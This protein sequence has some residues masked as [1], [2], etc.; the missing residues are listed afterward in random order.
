M[1][2]NLGQLNKTIEQNN[3]TTRLFSSNLKLN[4]WSIE[5]ELIEQL[6]I[7]QK[8]LDKFIRT[9]EQMVSWTS[10]PRSGYPLTTWCQCMK[11]DEVCPAW[12]ATAQILGTPCLACYR[13]FTGV[14]VNSRAK[15]TVG[16]PARCLCVQPLW[17]KPQQR[18]VFREALNPWRLSC[19][20]PNHNWSKPWVLE[21]VI[22]SSN[23]WQHS[24]FWSKHHKSHWCVVQAD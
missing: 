15:G 12:R 20:D 2:F 21:D 5:L 10:V 13:L 17:S 9:T 14:V 3:N 8:Q 1:Q 6:P 11:I 19:L 4:K 16:D 18:R 24:K 23:P 7:E 22:I